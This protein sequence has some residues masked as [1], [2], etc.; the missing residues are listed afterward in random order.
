MC[1]ISGF[2]SFTN[3]DNYVTTALAK[4]NIDM[5]YRGPDE[6]SVWSD[7]NVALSHVRLSIIG[8]KNGQQPMFNED[9]SITLICNGEIYNYKE[10]KKKLIQKGY[11]FKSESDCEVIIYLYEEHK[12]ACVNHIKGMFSFA[13]WDSKM[14]QLLLARDHAGKKPLYFTETPKGIAFSSEVNILKKY[15][16]V[17]PEL[18]SEVIR[19]V[20]KY[21]YSL[22]PDQTY[23]KQVKKIPPGCYGKIDLKKG[24]RITKYFKRKI[25][26]SFD[27]DYKLAI[28]KV[29]NL[30]N[31]AVEIRLQSEVPLALLLSA[32][33]DSSSIA[34]IAKDQGHEIHA[35][36][37]GYKGNFKVDERKEA[38]KFAKQK[39]IVFHEIEI[40]ERH[41]NE[42][43]EEILPKL[44]EPN[45]DVAMFAQWAIYK[46]AKK[47]GFKVLINGNGADELF[48]GYQSHNDTIKLNAV[49]NKFPI[50]S[51][52]HLIKH[53]IKFILSDDWKIIQ[54]INTNN[55]QKFNGFDNITIDKES[56]IN[57]SNLN[58]LDSYYNFLH[59]AWLTNNCYFLSDKLAMAHSI[60]MR[61]PFADQD[62]VSFVD[63]LPLKIKYKDETPKQ[64]LI[65]SMRGILPEDILNRQK[66]GFTP[67]YSFINEVVNR[68]NLKYDLDLSSLSELTSDYFIRTLKN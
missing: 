40:N 51:R 64:L 56:W 58:E 26:S 60:E 19:Q 54:N 44:D 22:M 25:L 20:N 63:S 24:L 5:S 13:L 67:P 14:K 12:E 23:I 11:T 42:Y 9:K 57:S 53:I 8:V 55:S 35:I 29:R 6:S 1:G 36:C 17:N 52:R 3:I 34:A 2:F 49:W 4:S 7:E 62:L 66:T 43:I 37:A 46:E 45:G 15:F 32:G 28:K 30:L 39:N 65:D 16:I 27:G 61:S 10:L 47:L 59:Y 48:Y 21:S 68:Y 18:N 33:V 31:N 38:K 50:S 41:Y